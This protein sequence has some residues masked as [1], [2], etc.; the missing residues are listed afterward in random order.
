MDLVYRPGHMVLGTPSAVEP[1]RS[2]DLLLPF[3]SRCGLRP[4]GQPWRPT[5]ATSRTRSAGRP[6]PGRADHSICRNLS[7]HNLSAHE[8]PAVQWLSAHPWFALHYTPT[9]ASWSKT[10]D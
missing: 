7:A 6:A 8:A 10:A 1:T 9:H 4:A 2:N 3:A 5:S